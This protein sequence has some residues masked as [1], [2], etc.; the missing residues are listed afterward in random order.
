MSY[1]ALAI[2]LLCTIVPAGAQAQ[3]TS[4]V[5]GTWIHTEDN[6]DPFHPGGL[7]HTEVDAQFLANGRLIINTNIT[8]PYLSGLSTAIWD[9]QITTSSS[10]SE[11][12]V[13]YEPKLNC[14]VGLC[15]FQPPFVPLGTK[16]VCAF[17]FEG[18]LFV[19]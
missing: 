18:E 4:L 11:V 14:G 15:G 19:T 7:Y 12:E 16:G 8:S 13:D 3:E 6:P 10:Y 1:R 2:A 17:Q 5:G 9:Y